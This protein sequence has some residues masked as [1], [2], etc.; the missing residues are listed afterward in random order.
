M[1]FDRFG[2]INVEASTSLAKEEDA[3]VV[4]EN[5]SMAANKLSY[6][7]GGGVNASQGTGKSQLKDLTCQ[8]DRGSRV[9]VVGANG[10]GK[11][12]LLSI[13]GGKKMI[14]RGQCQIYGKEVFHDTELHS[15]VMYCGDWWRTDFFFNLSISELLGD[16]MKEARCQRLLEILQVDL[17][18]RIN[19]ISDGQRRRCQLLECLATEKSFYIMDEITTDLDL[20]AREGLLNFL[21]AETEERG[22]TIFYATHIF[23]CLAD[24]AT[25]ILFFKGGEP[26]KCTSMAELKEYHDLVAAK[27][28]VPLYSLMKRWVFEEYP[29]ALSPQGDT[30]PAA[31]HVDGPVIELNNMT[32]TYAEGLPP[33]LKDMTLAIERGARCL[34]IG[35]N[36]ACKSTVMSILGGKRMIGR[37]K[38][39]VMQKDAFNDPGLGREVM[40]MGDWWRTKFFMNLRFSELLPEEVRKS[41]RCEHLAKILEV[42]LEWKINSLS[43][44]MRRRCQLLEALS[45]P[46]AVYFMDE[47][48]SD[49]DIYAREGILNFLRA[50]SEIRGATILYCTHIFDH[51]EGWASH[52][53]HL[54]QGTVVKCCA[55]SEVEEYTQLLNEKVACPLYNLVRRWVY[56]EYDRLIE[57]NAKAPKIV[58]SL[59]G[60]IPNLGLAGPFM[61]TCG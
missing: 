46:K 24:W 38:A 55:M 26:F 14:P 18:W 2:V 56:D 28:R 61:T 40:Y 47:I 6:T 30:G 39:W 54:S 59:D 36:G 50:E 35:A 23:D 57:Q 52:L 5:N 17:N 9:L 4:G 21:R 10:A 25:H 44:G 58:Q 7:Y 1:V 53:L 27:D 34:V 11:S 20:Y 15:Q 49:L 41:Y 22:A 60:R 12:T 33:V 31:P 19:A 16:K 42:D 3:M 45:T 48:T 37:N 13:L 29:E 43:D 8:F 32:Y 51:L